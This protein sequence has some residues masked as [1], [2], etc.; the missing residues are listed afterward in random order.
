[1]DLA[2]TIDWKEHR[3]VSDTVAL[4]KHEAFWRPVW[5]VVRFPI[6]GAGAVLLT[7]GAQAV[8]ESYRAA[9][10]SESVYKRLAAGIRLL[11]LASSI[12]L[13][14]NDIKLLDKDS[15]F[16]KAYNWVI[17]TFKTKTPASSTATTV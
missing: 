7:A 1:M 13:K 2:R 15:A 17:N 5:D 12:Y 10:F 16:K 4:D 11:C 9:Y 6:F 8:Y 3:E 14:D